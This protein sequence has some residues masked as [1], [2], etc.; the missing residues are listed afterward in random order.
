[1]HSA[2]GSA[3]LATERGVDA[4]AVEPLADE[5]ACGIGADGGAI[6]AIEIGA[7]EGRPSKRGSAHGEVEVQAVRRQRALEVGEKLRMGVGRRNCIALAG[8]LVEL[9][10]SAGKD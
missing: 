1:M 3:D 4:G 2:S 6:D 7:A 8:V 5:L 9:P 10:D